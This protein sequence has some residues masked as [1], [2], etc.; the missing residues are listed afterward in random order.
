MSL[1]GGHN[2]THQ[3]GSSKLQDESGPSFVHP[4]GRAA[5]PLVLWH[6]TSWF[7]RNQESPI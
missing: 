2:S 6:L 5:V 1:A 4:R 3:R 7:L